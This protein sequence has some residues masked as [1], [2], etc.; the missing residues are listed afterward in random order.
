MDFAM[1]GHASGHSCRTLGRDM[2]VVGVELLLVALGPGPGMF[3]LGCGGQL[4]GPLRIPG[5]V[6]VT[7]Q[8]EQ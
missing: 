1:V 4:R 6:V 8:P 7:R 5:C 2:A 3:R